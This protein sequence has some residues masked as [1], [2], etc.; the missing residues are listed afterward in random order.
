[1]LFEATECGATFDGKTHFQNK[2]C[3]R[4]FFPELLRGR[5]REGVHL[6]RTQT[7]R[8]FRDLPSAA[9]ALRGEVRTGKRPDHS[10]LKQGAA[11]KKMFI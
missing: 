4:L 10:G 1:M 6:Q 9:D 3:V 2:S 5:R 11:G 8:P 7:H